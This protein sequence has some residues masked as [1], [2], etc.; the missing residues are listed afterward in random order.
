MYEKIGTFERECFKKLEFS[1][2]EDVLEDFLKSSNEKF[3]KLKGFKKTGLEGLWVK[4]ERNPDNIDLSKKWAI[5][6]PHN[7]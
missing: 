3:M 2:Y 5:N 1:L 7:P 6:P 4:D